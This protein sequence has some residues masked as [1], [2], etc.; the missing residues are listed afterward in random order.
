[1]D[2]SAAHTTAEVLKAIFCDRRTSPRASS[3]C[4]AGPHAWP[5]EDFS[6]PQRW[7]SDFFQPGLVSVQ[8]LFDHQRHPDLVRQLVAELAARLPKFGPNDEPPETGFFGKD[9]SSNTEEGKKV[10]PKALTHTWSSVE[11]EPK[12]SFRDLF[13]EEVW[14]SM[15]KPRGVT[16]T[17]LWDG[18]LE[19]MEGFLTRFKTYREIVAHQNSGLVDDGGNLEVWSSEGR[20]WLRRTLWYMHQRQDSCLLA[21]RVKSQES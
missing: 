1:M 6:D 15:H 16:K 12:K 18:L 4:G 14:A 17:E 13:T 9:W 21:S 2:G 8:Y 19:K 20:Y 10:K 3:S 5:L 11:G 7:V